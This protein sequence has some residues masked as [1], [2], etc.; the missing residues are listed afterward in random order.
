MPRS[1]RLVLP[2]QIHHVTQRGVRSQEIFWTDDDRLLYLD[3]LKYESKRQR[4]KILAYC[5]MTNH[6]HFLMVPEEALGL[7]RVIG[8][9]HQKYSAAINRQQGQRGFLFQGRFY[10][11]PLDEN[12]AAHAARYVL[13]NPV[14]AKMVPRAEDWPWSSAGFHIGA[15]ETDPLVARHDLFGLAPDIRTWRTIAGS[16]E[17]PTESHLHY[18]QIRAQTRLGRPVGGEEFWAT[19]TQVAGRELVVRPKGRPHGTITKNK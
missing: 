6:V 7:A 8:V 1:A 12:H 13:H 2:G 5:L 17:E 11:C 14:R 4:V 3:L 10:S 9:T 18:D 19:A 15:R 16:D